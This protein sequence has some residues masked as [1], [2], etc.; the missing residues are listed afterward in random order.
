M[1]IQFNERLTFEGYTYRPGEEYEVADRLGAMLR[2][3]FEPFIVEPEEPAS[4]EPVEEEKPATRKRRT[5][6]TA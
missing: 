6:R 5:E 2:H 3:N 4:V 1:K